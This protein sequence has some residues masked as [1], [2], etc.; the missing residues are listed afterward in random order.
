MVRRWPNVQIMVAFGGRVIESFWHMN[1]TLPPNHLDLGCGLNPRN[2]YR[3][4]NLYGIDIRADSAQVTRP[5][6]QIV[7]G[8][9][10]LSPI[11]FADN[12]M[13]SMSAFDFFEHV[14]RQLYR[15]STNEIFCPFVNLMSEIWRVLAPG[16]RLLAVTPAYPHTS[17]FID[18]THVN[19]ITAESHTYFCGEKPAGAIY[20]FKG[21]FR[22]LMVK[23]TTL[24]NVETLPYRPVRS[25]FRDCHR[26][27][28]RNGVHHLVW[29]LEA[30]K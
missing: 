19:I 7:T 16:G 29:E 22:P 26:R 18:P 30:V 6:C 9:V 2:P 10:A 1:P 20:G 25:W 4:Q 28:F 21:R 23:F 15:E 3:R 5:N 17:A 13:G 12:F 8:N 27:L 14:P 11:P 24:S